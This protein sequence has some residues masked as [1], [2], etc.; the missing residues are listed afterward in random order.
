MTST[1]D[2]FEEGRGQE[3]RWAEKA[4]LTDGRISKRTWKP[5]TPNLG[6]GEIG[7][8]FVEN[9]RETKFTS[10]HVKSD[11]R[12]RGKLIQISVLNI[13]DSVIETAGNSGKVHSIHSYLGRGREVDL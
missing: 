5:W 10:N 8:I 9:S 4:Q 11:I 12:T 13:M 2:Q 1:V 3:S 7:D 6:K